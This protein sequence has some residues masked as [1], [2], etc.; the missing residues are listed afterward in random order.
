MD[1]LGRINPEVFFRL[2]LK[3]PTSAAPWIKPIKQYMVVLIAQFRHLAE[4]SAEID[5][6]SSAVS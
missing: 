1:L 4:K 6:S 5:P 2:V 3:R